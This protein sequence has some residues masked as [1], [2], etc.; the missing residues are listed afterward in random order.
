[1]SPI[2]YYQ[3]TRRGAGGCCWLSN[4]LMWI[5][6]VRPC[7]FNRRAVIFW[8][9]WTCSYLPTVRRVALFRRK[10]EDDT[11]ESDLIIEN[12]M[13]RHNS[14]RSNEH[15]VTGYSTNFYHLAIL[16]FCCKYRGWCTL[17]VNW[18]L[19]PVYHNDRLHFRTNLDFMP[20]ICHATMHCRLVTR[21]HWPV[22]ILA[23]IKTVKHIRSN[24]VER[25]KITMRE[26]H[27]LQSSYYFTEPLYFHTE[28]LH[29]G[30]MYVCSTLHYWF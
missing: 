18:L 23:V 15:L 4:P 3:E 9:M 7:W 27:P 29:L 10:E 16:I 2:G 1:M 6:V 21:T 19:M 24:L 17:P 25:F 28:L 22:N 5:I 26:M 12:G 13:R 30:T 8:Q 20:I 11:V 14:L